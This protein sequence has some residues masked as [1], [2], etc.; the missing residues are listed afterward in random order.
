MV[1]EVLTREARQND[2]S[3][4]KGKNIFS[5]DLRRES[6][7]ILQY[8]PECRRVQ[9][10]RLLP[11]RIFVDLVKR[12][13]VALV[14]LYKYFALDEDQVLFEAPL[15]EAEESELPVIAGLETKIFGPKSGTKY[16]IKELELALEVIK[17][18]RRNRILRDYK[19]RKIDVPSTT[20]ASVFIIPGSGDYEYM[21]STLRY[22]GLEVKLSSDRVRY[23]MA[24][25]ANLIVAARNE[26]NKIKYIDFRFKEPVI[27][28]KDVP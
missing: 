10:V 26:W 9:L 19:I 15:S 8:F 1:R 3:Y 17:E 16:N 23:K 4:L 12:K 13:A 11:G 2:F 28:L 24:L 21:D 18:A 22:E 20:G 14:K 27:K 6:R 5:I 7:N 25:L